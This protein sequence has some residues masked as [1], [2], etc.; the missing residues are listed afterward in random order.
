VVDDGIFRIMTKQCGV[1]EEEEDE[2]RRNL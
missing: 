1:E 2:E